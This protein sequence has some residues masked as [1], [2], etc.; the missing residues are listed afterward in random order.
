MASVGHCLIST[1][2]E[3]GVAFKYQIS[4][5][6]TGKDKRSSLLSP[7]PVTKKKSFST[8]TPVRRME[9]AKYEQS[10]QG[11]NILNTLISNLWG[12]GD[13]KLPFSFTI[14]KKWLVQVGLSRERLVYGQT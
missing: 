14:R 9:T 6:K 4:L 10:R 2:V 7:S 11:K 3:S 12:G 5:K 13:T 1:R 8:L